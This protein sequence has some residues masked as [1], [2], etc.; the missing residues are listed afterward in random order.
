MSPAV[1]FVAW[2]WEADEVV[3]EMPPPAVR[4][5]RPAVMEPAVCVIAPVV[6]KIDIWLAPLESA[7]LSW[8]P[9]PVV[10]R[11]TKIG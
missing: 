11:V 3:I 10:T 7:P 5:S 6:L 2:S 8:K 1:A 9:A 4:L